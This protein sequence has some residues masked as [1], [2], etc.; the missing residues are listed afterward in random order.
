MVKLRLFT[1]PLNMIHPITG[2]S[3][4]SPN[5]NPCDGR[6]GAVA[7]PTRGFH[8]DSAEALA[9]HAHKTQRHLHGE[10]VYFPEYFIRNLWATCSSS[11]CTG[12]TK[13]EP[14]NGC[15]ASHARRIGR[16]DLEKAKW[17]LESFFD[18][19]IIMEAFSSE[20]V[21]HYL[22]RTLAEKLNVPL[23]SLAE[24]VLGWRRN[25]RTEKGTYLRAAG[26]KNSSSPS[27]PPGGIKRRLRKESELDLELYSFAVELSRK[28][29]AEAE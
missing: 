10:G 5:R 21:L 14:A 3:L 11:A 13:S 27:A 12:L 1:E 4:R 22:Q 25:G 16:G 9:C 2:R 23:E 28:R 17:I 18:L 26:H 6:Y 7:E 19:V 29:M 20:K 24:L 8:H 15:P